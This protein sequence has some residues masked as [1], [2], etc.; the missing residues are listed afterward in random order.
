MILTERFDGSSTPFEGDTTLL[1]KSLPE[2]AQVSK[3]AL[4][5]TPRSRSATAPF[6]EII[7]FTGGTQQW[8]ATQ[9]SGSNNSQFWVEVDFHTRRTLTRIE[10]SYGAQCSLQMDLGGVYIEINDKGA[11]KVPDEGDLFFVPANGLVPGLSANKFKLTQA[12]SAPLVTRLTVR[13]APTNLTARLGGDPPFFARP[14]ELSRPENSPDFTQTLQAFLDGNEADGGFYQVPLVLH[15][16]SIARLDVELQVEYTLEQAVLPAGLQETTLDYDQSGQPKAGSASIEVYL[17]AGARLIPGQT[18]VRVR[19]AF[20]ESRIVFGPSG[21]VTPAGSLAVTPAVSQ[22]APILLDADLPVTSFDLL[23]ASTTRTATLNIN[24]MEDVDGKVWN[25]A[26]LSRPVVITLDRDVAQSATWITASLPAEFQFH[27]GVRY[28]LVVQCLSGE[29]AWSASTAGQGS[30]GMQYSDDGG[31]SWRSSS[32]S[33]VTGL[34]DG[35]L[36]LR[37]VPA[38]FTMPIELQVGEGDAAQR[39]DLSRYEP[40][41]RVDFTLDTAE[42]AAAF[43]QVVAAAEAAAC[44]RGNHLENNEFIDWRRTGDEPG[45]PFHL[46]MSGGARLVA[47]SADGCRAFAASGDGEG[48]SLNIAFIDVFGDEISGR[49]NLSEGEPTAMACTADG[50]RVYLASFSRIFIVDANERVSLG[51]FPLSDGGIQAMAVSPDG[52]RLYVAVYTYIGG[53][54]GGKIYTLSTQAMLNQIANSSLPASSAVLG[55]VVDLGGSREPVAMTISPDGGSLYIVVNRN[56]QNGSGEIYQM[57]ANAQVLIGSP[58]QVDDNP[59]RA[60]LT[61]DGTRLAVAHSGPDQL[62]ILN[63]LNQ[64]IERI[65][66]APGSAPYAVA[67]SP[68]AKMAFVALNE[69]AALAVVNLETGRMTGQ[70]AVGSM[71]NDIAI[72]PDGQ[73]V[74]VADFMSEPQESMSVLPVGLLLPEEWTLTAGRV[75]PCCFPAPFERAAIVGDL[76]LDQPS[77]SAGLSQVVAASGGCRY[78]FSFSG[79]ATDSDAFGEVLWISPECG[80]LQTDRVPIQFVKQPKLSGASFETGASNKRNNLKFLRKFWEA[81]ARRLPEKLQHNAVLTAPTGATQAEVRFTTPPGIAAA[82]DRITLQATGETIANSDLRQVQGEQLSGWQ[83][84]PEN[85][86]G[87]SLVADDETVQIHN[88]GTQTVTLQQT[89]SFEPSTNFLLEFGGFALAKSGARG[90]PSVELKW[91]NA[92]GQPAGAPGRLEIPAGSSDRH[93]LAG[94]SPAQTAQAQV[95]INVPAGAA[96]AIRRVS[97]QPAQVVRIPVT[98][99]AQAPGELTITDWHVA[100]EI[101]EPQPPPIPPSGLCTPTRP[102]GIPGEAGECC[103]CPCCEGEHELLDAEEAHTPSGKPAHKGRCSNCGCQVVQPG[104]L[105][106]ASIQPRPTATAQ[107]RPAAQ[108]FTGLRMVRAAPRIEVRQVLAVAA[109]PE[110]ILQVERLPLEAIKGVRAKRSAQLAELGID[111]IEKLATARPEDITVIKGVS[112][113]MAQ[114]WIEEAHRMRGMAMRRGS[115]SPGENP[116]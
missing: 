85:P 63:L 35:L 26:L 38:R 96:L 10:G 69:I 52:Q 90:S 34:L 8:G 111:S 116:A 31:L 1:L 110:A 97:L 105:P 47:V 30:A 13:S 64:D 94:A 104:A 62:T 25:Q 95:Q 39:V 98:F 33:G 20:Q 5:L 78:E 72:T 42:V 16:D 4:M 59:Q 102:A 71:P 6:E 15:S 32:V 21:A 56:D 74:Y 92:S 103:Y 60:C 84:L 113:E 107:T 73:R 17:P 14:G 23:L 55:T 76:D 2:G 61:S 65:P 27:A 87:V 75:T 89:A 83:V 54:N 93:S 109:E 53:V 45:A 67:L 28:W 101:V 114:Q 79:F 7:Q 77:M 82:I 12:G 58:Q 29:A 115:K 100:Y 40:L 106:A 91:L 86:R 51:V 3:A 57:D 11:V 49:L 50:S 24:I 41:G 48:G 22:A 80:L 99:V 66:L 9:T 81:A 70:I 36:R 43:N 68:E 46:N 88:S 112:R 108:V 37:N 18:R 44:P 19:G